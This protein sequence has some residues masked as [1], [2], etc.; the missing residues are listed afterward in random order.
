[1][2]CLKL[3]LV[4]L[5]VS[6]GSVSTP[7][8]ADPPLQLEGTGQR[9]SLALVPPF[10]QNG[11]MTRFGLA[12]TTDLSGDLDSTEPNAETFRCK[13]VAESGR[14][15]CRGE[16]LFTGTI[17]GV[18]EGTTLSKVTARCDA[19]GACDI[20]FRIKGVSGALADVRGTGTGHVSPDGAVTYSVRLTRV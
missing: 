11:N 12:V 14:T 10:S 15:A 1:M 8:W 17:V 13:T 2:K 18:G 3:C 4:V 9:Q 7:A 16:A 5:A 19:A 20:R 6:A